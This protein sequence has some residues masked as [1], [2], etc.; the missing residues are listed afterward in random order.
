MNK[1]DGGGKSDL[2]LADVFVSCDGESAVRS[3]LVSERTDISVLIGR[4]RKVDN[5]K[6]L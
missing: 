3:E 6:I 1:R 5:L 4:W 2:E